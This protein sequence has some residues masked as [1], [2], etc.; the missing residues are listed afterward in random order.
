MFDVD[1]YILERNQQQR[2]SISQ[3]TALTDALRETLLK[4]FLNEEKMKEEGQIEEFRLINNLHQFLDIQ[5]KAHSLEES[6]YRKIKNHFNGTFF[7]YKNKTNEL[8]K[9][10]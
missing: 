4:K 9:K 7:K 8:S 3:A 10:L 5:C 2:Q 1:T 6:E